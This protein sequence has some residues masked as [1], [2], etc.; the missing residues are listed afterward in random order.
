MNASVDIDI[1]D[2]H[3]WGNPDIKVTL[4]NLLQIQP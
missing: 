1:L 4:S 3:I 2:I